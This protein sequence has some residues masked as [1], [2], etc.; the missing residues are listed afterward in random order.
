MWCACMLLALYRGRNKFAT[1]HGLSGFTLQ[2]ILSSRADRFVLDRE[3]ACVNIR[4]QFSCYRTRKYTMFVSGSSR[5]LLPS[6]THC[7]GIPL[8][9]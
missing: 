6:V 1:P 4:A 2:C 9:V 8:Q 3:H 5:L 7:S